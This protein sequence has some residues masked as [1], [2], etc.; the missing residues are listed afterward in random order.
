[1]N[2]EIAGVYTTNRRKRQEE[3]RPLASLYEYDNMSELE[4]PSDTELTILSASSNTNAII[5]GVLDSD[6]DSDLDRNNYIADSCGR[7]L[8]VKS[9]VSISMVEV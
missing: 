4:N 2:G 1:M 5:Q 7:S 6:S 9:V 3:S 8:S